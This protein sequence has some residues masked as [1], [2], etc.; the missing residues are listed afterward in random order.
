MACVYYA[1]RKALTADNKV[2]KLLGYNRHTSYPDTGSALTLAQ[3][4]QDVSFLSE[5]GAVYVRGGHYPQDQRFLD[6]C[7][8][9]QWLPLR[10]RDA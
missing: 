7:D 3:V 10:R 6:L 9:C 4:Q 2:V 5:I 1:C 8:S